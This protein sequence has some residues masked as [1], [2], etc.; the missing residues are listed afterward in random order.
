M[1]EVYGK[2]IATYKGTCSL[3]LEAGNE[4]KGAL[5]AI[6]LP[7]GQIYLHV[8]I[9]KE[10]FKS[11]PQTTDVVDFWSSVE[12][13]QGF[14]SD[15]KKLETKGA[16]HLKA[17]ED[18]LGINGKPEFLFRAQCTEITEPEQGIKT[19]KIR[20]HLTNLIFS[21]QEWYTD[22]E[23]R[24]QYWITVIKYKGLR[25]EI[26]P[27]KDVQLQLKDMKATK[28][29][30]L[31]SFIDI[32]PSSRTVPTIESYLG[33]I[34][35]ILTLAKGTG[36]TWV[37]Y[38]EF[39]STGK[40]KRV[41]H[42]DAPT[43]AYSSLK[44]IA[45]FPP[46]LLRD[47]TEKCLSNIRSFLDV[48]EMNKHINTIT[49]AKQDGGFLELRA[50]LLA[51][52]IDIIAGIWGTQNGCADIVEPI[53][54]RKAQGVLTNELKSLVSRE[55]SLAPKEVEAMSSHIS[56]LNRYS[57]RTK[58]KRMVDAFSADITKDEIKNFVDSRNHLVHK[59]EFQ[60]SDKSKEF[61]SIVSFTDR[62]TMAMLGYKG[63]Y[64]DVRTFR[65]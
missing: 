51:S 27:R 29:P 63:E 45:E 35:L 37:Y 50:L 13:I 58:L 18:F 23:S 6:Q 42:R 43:R 22:T 38:E 20:F 65:S 16:I 5:E 49:L 55:L 3:I 14:L 59:G 31:T 8:A 56:S 57:L 30:H 17:T 28:Q 24:C 48:Y 52:A 21:G 32:K 12:T 46:S 11:I 34:V 1:L 36:V 39:T 47:F 64:F 60:T 15:G 25:F 7:D 4:I 41:M 54:F 33:A 40:V 53:L 2:P 19:E 61:L 10:T 26:H 44:L 62:L 9:N